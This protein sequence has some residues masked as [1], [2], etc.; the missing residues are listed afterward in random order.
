M[1][2][3][4]AREIAKFLPAAGRAFCSAYNSFNIQ[5]GQSTKYLP[6]RLAVLMQLREL[7][8]EECVQWVEEPGIDLFDYIGRDE[9]FLAA[10]EHDTTETLPVQE[11]EQ[12]NSRLRTELAKYSPQRRFF[13]TA[14]GFQFFF[15]GTL[16]VQILTGTELISPLVALTGM[17]VGAVVM[18]LSYLRELEIRRSR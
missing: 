2:V 9:E 12:E 14:M 6:P 1:A 5:P 15:S 7:V 18:L 17:T 13:H 3:E 16:L 4:F 11:L 8:G 10:E